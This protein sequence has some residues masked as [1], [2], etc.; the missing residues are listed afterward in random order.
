MSKDLRQPMRPKKELP[1]IEVASRESF[2]SWTQGSQCSCAGLET[3]VS[4]AAAEPLRYNLVTECC[5]YHWPSPQQRDW[6]WAL[7][8]MVPIIQKHSVR[9][10]L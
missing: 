5:I 1:K 10:L 3:R 4:N 2:P 9:V 8:K 6:L 7:E